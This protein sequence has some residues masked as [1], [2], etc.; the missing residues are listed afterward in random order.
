MK[1]NRDQERAQAEEQ[2]RAAVSRR[3]EK[4]SEQR[5]EDSPG[6]IDLAEPQQ[7]ITISGST[8]SQPH[9]PSS[10]LST[11]V[12]SSPMLIQGSTLQS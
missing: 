1:K 10:G 7:P 5:V 9:R 4:M 2:A 8:D 12:K 6:I 3:P 11:S